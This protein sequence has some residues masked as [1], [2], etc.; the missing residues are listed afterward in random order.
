LQMQYV[1]EKNRMK[2]LTGKVVWLTGASSGIGE[3]LAI[4]LAKEGCKLILSARRKNELQRVQKLA[5]LSDDN[6][7][8]LPLDLEQ[9]QD[10]ENLKNIALQK[11]NRIDVLINN[12][13]ISQRSLAIET[14]IEVDKRLMEV[15]YIGTVTL[16]KTLL[17]HFIK[18]KSGLIV[19]VT[20]AVGKIPSPWRSSYAAA[21]HALHGFFDSLRAECYQ[22][23]LRVLL[24]CPGFVATNVSVNALTG[25]GETTGKMDAAT[26]KGI[27]A[28]KCAQGIV[29]AMK[30]EKQEVVIGGIKEKFGVWTKRHFPLLFSVMIRKMAVR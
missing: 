25:N 1:L 7:L 19:T 2:T 10:F 5:E 18:N 13:G 9:Y 20:S 8:L 3:A 29:A 23:G 6:C 28:K 30:A 22:D 24:V 21:K 14:S 17:P 26:A 16:T 12:A 4:E 27:S 11:F 15:N